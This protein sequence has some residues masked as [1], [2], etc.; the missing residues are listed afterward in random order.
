MRGKVASVIT[1]TRPISATLGTIASKTG[2][3][4]GPLAPARLVACGRH[5]SE[6]RGPPPAIYCHPKAKAEACV[7]LAAC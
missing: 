6:V 5:S 1:E 3:L 7:A 4:H 2:R